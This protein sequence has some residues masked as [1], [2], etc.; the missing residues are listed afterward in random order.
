MIVMGLTGDT[1]IDFKIDQ[2][3]SGVGASRHR[4]SIDWCCNST[5]PDVSDFQWI[6]QG[7]VVIMRFVCLE[8]YVKQVS[9]RGY[10]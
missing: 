4:R 2:N 7:P 1:C 8:F 5:G 3:Q 6:S 9:V 10:G